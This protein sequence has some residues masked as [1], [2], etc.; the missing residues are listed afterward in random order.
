M[1]DNALEELNAAWDEHDTTEETTHEPEHQ[2]EEQP[3]E[4]AEHEESD[5]RPEELGQRGHEDIQPDPADEQAV[6]ASDGPEGD[7]AVPAVEGPAAPVGLPAGAREVWPDTPPAMQEAIAQR[8]KDYAQGIQKYA[9]SAKRAE[10][11]DQALAP[12]HQYFAMNGNQPA[13]TM[14]GLLQTASILQMGSPQQRAEQVAGLIN[15]FGVDIPTLDAILTGNANPEGA[16]PIPNNQNQ[17]DINMAVQQAI[18]PYQQFMDQ[19]AQYQQEATQQTQQE[20]QQEIIA[21]ANDPKNEFYMDVRADMA[22]I[23]DMATNRQIEMTLK[24]A[25]DKAC[26]LRPDIQKILQGREQQS[27][28]RQ[29]RTAATSVSGTLGGSGEGS[30]PDSLRGA[31][32]AAWEGD[33]RA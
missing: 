12:F 17:H 8:E 28:M 30:A 21:F 9:E 23:M 11:M 13:D 4:P 3:I 20:V 6:P 29:R 24:E 26:L 27:A 15:Q 1:G 19:Q 22:D 2:P 25:Y 14:H 5:E 18:A 7:V 33:G 10:M 16:P 31:L 32:E